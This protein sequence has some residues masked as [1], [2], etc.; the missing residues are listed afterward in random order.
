[1]KVYKLL[2][3]SRN[4]DLYSLC[5]DEE[6]FCWYICKNDQIIKDSS[7]YNNLL[8]NFK[9]VVKIN[10]SNKTMFLKYKTEDLE[11]LELKSF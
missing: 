4:N 6:N 8:S 5:Y 9:N 1:M 7:D 11:R 3:L 10:L 2:E